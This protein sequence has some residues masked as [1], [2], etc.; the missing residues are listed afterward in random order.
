MNENRKLAAP[1]KR[2]QDDVLRLRSELEA[3]R[4]EKAEM[5]R[6]K[7]ALVIVEG[8]QSTV[9]WEHETLLQRFGELKK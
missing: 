7:A 9:M 1:L 6:I 2:M 3:Y 8:S 5:R 4:K